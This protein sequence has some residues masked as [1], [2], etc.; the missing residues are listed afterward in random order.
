T[1][2]AIGFDTEEFEFLR[3]LT[4]GKIIV[5]D[6]NQLFLSSP[7]NPYA[8]LCVSPLLS[9]DSSFCIVE[10][11]IKMLKKRKIKG[12]ETRIN[13]FL[14]SSNY[15]NYI[16]MN[17]WCTHGDGWL[18]NFWLHP[19][20]GDE[21]ALRMSQVYIDAIQRVLIVVAHPFK[22]VVVQNLHVVVLI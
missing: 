10:M 1:S 17:L 5:V 4:F 7:E 19:L 14:L 3:N 20:L 2:S 8:C 15:V 11:V 9:L 12:M 13:S 22:E 21:I 18:I 16:L 6:E